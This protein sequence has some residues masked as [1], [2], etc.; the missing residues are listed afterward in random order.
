M[1]GQDFITLA[2]FDVRSMFSHSRLEH[3]FSLTNIFEITIGACNQVNKV[4]VFAADVPVCLVVNGSIFPVGIRT[5][6]N[7]VMIY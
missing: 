3:S 2:I 5:I 7:V 1:T 4:G 6:E